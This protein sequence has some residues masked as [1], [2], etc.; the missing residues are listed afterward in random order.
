M[1]M[2]ELLCY[3]SVQFLASILSWLGFVGPC[4]RWD[5]T[6]LE[7]SRVAHAPSHWGCR[8]T[9]LG[10]MDPV[11]DN[12]ITGPLSWDFNRGAKLVGR[13]RV[14]PEYF[15]RSVVADQ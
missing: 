7:S 13:E 3:P 2:R 10:P 12:A 5:L 14:E 1:S 8:V 11:V 15:G 4:G 9:G 6:A